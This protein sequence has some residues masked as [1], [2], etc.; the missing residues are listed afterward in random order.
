MVT[1]RKAK[2]INLQ[3][4]HLRPLPAEL[5][6]GIIAEEVEGQHGQDDRHSRSA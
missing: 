6:V 1:D 4:G 3:A 5:V 2:A